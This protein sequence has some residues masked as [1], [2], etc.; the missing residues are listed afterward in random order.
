MADKKVRFSADDRETIRRHTIGKPTGVLVDLSGVEFDLVPLTTAQGNAI[1]EILDAVSPLISK[2]DAGGNVAIAQT[3]WAGIVAAEGRRVNSIL[4]GI[5]LASAKATLVPCGETSLPLFDPDDADSLA[6][7]DEWF[8][9]LPLVETVRT[10]FPKLLE[11][12]GMTT[13]M[14]N[15]S[16]PQPEEATAPA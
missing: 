6:L 15:S 9:A 10:L 16:T 3:A 8:E 14:G 13:L 12:Q 2:A 1:F 11:A 5:L 7:F 4:R